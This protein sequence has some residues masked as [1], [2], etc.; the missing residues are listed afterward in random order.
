[1]SEVV[2]TQVLD[3]DGTMEVTPRSD[4][5]SGKGSGSGDYSSQGI[6]RSQSCGQRSL[7]VAGSNIEGV[8]WQQLESLKLQQNSGSRPRSDRGGYSVEK[9][10]VDP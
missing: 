7:V 3:S 5:G 4:G 2:T 8:F 1:M 6:G 10:D 9:Y